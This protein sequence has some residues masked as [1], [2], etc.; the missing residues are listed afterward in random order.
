MRPISLHH[1][2]APELAATELVALAARLG[3]QHV[4]LFTQAPLPNWRFPTVEQ[5]NVAEVGRRMADDGLTAYGITSFAVQPGVDVDD[6]AASLERG[7][8]L[9][10]QYASVRIVDADEARAT[11][12]FGRLAALAASFGIV[13]SIEF[14]GY[15]EPDALHRT[16]RILD[17]AGAGALSIDPL[18]IVRSEASLDAMRAI[19]PGRIGYVQLCDGPAHASAED[20]LRESAAERMAPGEGA[21]PLAE[22]LALAP[23]GRTVSLEIPSERQR[24]EGAP[25]ELRARKAVEATR[26]FLAQAEPE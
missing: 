25:A 13:A 10:A 16:L 23:P 22:I 14:T 20:Y 6:Y 11:D 3:C 26:R 18:H 24:A 15:R 7:A 9:G 12:A 5:A 17:A 1:I 21:F 8:R 19:E 2:L 4:C